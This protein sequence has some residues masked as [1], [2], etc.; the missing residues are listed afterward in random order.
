MNFKTYDNVIG[1]H[2]K[3]YTCT[4]LLFLQHEEKTHLNIVI[5]KKKLN[6]PKVR[7][8]LLLQNGCEVKEAT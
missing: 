4:F 3:A 8:T 5:H 7:V 2:H 6:E 1:V